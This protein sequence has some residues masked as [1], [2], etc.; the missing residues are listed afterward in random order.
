MVCIKI[1]LSDNIF[2]EKEKYLFKGIHCQHSLNFKNVL[3][4]ESMDKNYVCG[5]EIKDFKI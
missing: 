2:H 3:E 1:A 4:N 5:H